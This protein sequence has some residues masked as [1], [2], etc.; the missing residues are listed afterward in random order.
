[1][2]ELTMYEMMAKGG[3]AKKITDGQGEGG[4]GGQNG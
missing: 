1:M 3:A 4:A 2:I